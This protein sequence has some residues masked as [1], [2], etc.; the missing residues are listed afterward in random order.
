MKCILWVSLF[1][2]V[3]AVP[4]AFAQTACPVGV[5]PGSPQCGP[6]SGTSRGD[7]P[8]PPPRPTGE[9]IKTWGAIATSKSMGEA[10][11]SAN[12]TSEDEARRIAIQE[13]ERGGAKDC[14]VN[15]AYHN[16]CAA[17]ASSQT[18]TFFQ[19]SGTEG[20]AAK[21]A[22]Q[23]CKDSNGGSCKVRYSECTNPVFRKY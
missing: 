19:A 22:M 20:R 8:S 23:S 2:L 4:S 18:D 14:E 11:T 16:Q 3:N 13:C 21:L 9:W 15:L 10:G 17:L 5:A 1:F 7:I 6:D 12:K